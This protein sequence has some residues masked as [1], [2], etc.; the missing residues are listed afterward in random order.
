MI[1]EVNEQEN[2]MSREWEKR[3]WRKNEHVRE[4]VMMMENEN[5]MKI[6]P[7]KQREGKERKGKSV[8]VNK[9]EE[10]EKG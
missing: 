3:K 8:Q 4:G 7:W 5:S 1:Q 2:E 10:E 6:K 9:K